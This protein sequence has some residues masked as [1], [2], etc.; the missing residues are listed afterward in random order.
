MGNQQRIDALASKQ[1]GAISL[2][3]TREAGFDRQAV[4]YR[5]KRGLWN[6]AAETVYVV[7]SSQPTW[8]RTLWIALLSRKQALLTHDTAAHLHGLP[9]FH[10]RQLKLL[11]PRRTNRR[12]S[13]TGIYESDQFDRIAYTTVNGLPVT[14][15]PETILVLARDRGPATIEKAFDEALIRHRLDL[16]AMSRVIDREKGRRTPGTPLLREL[17]KTRRP[18]APS[19]EATVLESLLERVLRVD[20]IPAWTREYEFALSDRAIR[21]DLFI[22]AASLVVEADGRN[23]HSRL[24]DFERDR[25]RDNELAARGIQVLRFTYTM[26]RFDSPN[27]RRL[28]LETCRHRAA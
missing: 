12:S 18:S 9:D 13:V 17:I 25:Q 5:I 7:A 4:H 19:W 28:V 8:E 2:A 20:E 22:P 1:H 3:Q 14:T 21:V 16:D 11:V 24:Q 10:R 6:Q 27:C 26:L 15:V 23:W